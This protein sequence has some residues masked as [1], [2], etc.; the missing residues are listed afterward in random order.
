VDALVEKYPAVLTLLGPAY[1]DF[2][3]AFAVEDAAFHVSRRS[4]LTEL[5]ADVDLRIDSCLIGLVNVVEGLTHHFDPSIAAAA[6]SVLARLKGYGPVSKK[7]YEDESGDVKKLIE[8]FDGPYKMKMTHLNLTAWIGELTLAE[9]QFGQLMAQRTDETTDRPDVNMRTARHATEEAYDTM[10][11][12]IDSDIVLNGPATCGVFVTYLNGRIDYF[13]HHANP[14]HAAKDI[15]HHVETS[16]VADQ[17]CT[18]KYLSPVF[19]WVRFVEAGK[20]PVDLFAGKDY[21]L[22]YEDNIKPGIGRII[23]H[24]K[25]QYKGSTTVT[26]HIVPLS[27]SGESES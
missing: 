3:A 1:T 16:D 5:L 7:S 9:A 23:I 11:N 6:K 15:R 25:G 2:K 10:R 18:G 12:I 27:V 21:L 26:F 13:N 8:D 20:E 19:E 14:R 22:T 17:A 24:G 4:D